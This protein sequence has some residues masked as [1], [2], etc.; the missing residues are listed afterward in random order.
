MVIPP[1]A[2]AS[3]TFEI[4]AEGYILSGKDTPPSGAMSSQ[5]V[6]TDVLVLQNKRKVNTAYLGLNPSQNHSDLKSAKFYANY[7]PALQGQWPDSYSSIQ[8]EWT[9]G[10]S[11]K[12]ECTVTNYPIPV[13]PVLGIGDT[14]ATVAAK[15]HVGVTT[16]IANVWGQKGNLFN[17]D[18]LGSASVTIVSVEI[19][20]TALSPSTTH[21]VTTQKTT[22]NKLPNDTGT[23][24]VDSG[25]TLPVLGYFDNFY[26]ILYP[27]NAE[28][29]VFFWN[30]INMRISEKGLK[31]LE[32]LE[33]D[34]DP[35]HQGSS[36][37]AEYPKIVGKGTADCERYPTI[38]YGHYML[39]EVAIVA[40]TDYN[41]GAMLTNTVPD[42]HGNPIL[43]YDPNGSYI[44][45]E[46]NL[47][48]R[49]GS[50]GG[51]SIDTPFS[52]ALGEKL[53]R[54]EMVEYYGPII[55]TFLFGDNHLRLRQWQYDACIM[56]IYK[57]GT[58][59]KDGWM[60][61]GMAIFV[62]N[63]NYDPIYPSVPPAISTAFGS[64]HRRQLVAELF[65]TGVYRDAYSGGVIL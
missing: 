3:F 61:R 38:G 46:G 5:G 20:E 15:N 42:R 21:T 2:G 34:Q 27:F 63:E 25:S 22:L 31:M 55:N 40:A 4:D 56:E 6:S 53:L 62:A 39:E 52:K 48:G 58:S 13:S 50:P 44:K 24:T 9:L 64:S 17:R 18:F 43:Y 14:Y 8:I 45:F 65:A 41:T 23:R 26:F 28:E 29:T 30:P 57:G 32:T 36:T 16:L 35:P 51:P 1:P 49:G 54:R 7:D 11:A 59:R 10:N 37:Y 33:G 12:F 60:S 47:Y 19:D